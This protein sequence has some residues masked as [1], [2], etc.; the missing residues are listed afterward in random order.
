MLISILKRLNEGIEE[1]MEIHRYTHG[2]NVD[3]YSPLRRKSTENCHI[4]KNVARHLGTLEGKEFIASE[5]V[6]SH[7]VLHTS[8][9]KTLAVVPFTP[10]GSGENDKDPKE[11]ISKLPL[12]PLSLPILILS[13]P[14]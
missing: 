6:A 5:T 13:R 9:S 12:F 2:S 14:L 1:A 8:K 4:D 3:H 7:R 11:I 10:R